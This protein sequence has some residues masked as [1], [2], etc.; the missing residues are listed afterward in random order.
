MKRGQLAYFVLVVSRFEM[1]ET[2]SIGLSGMRMNAYSHSFAAPLNPLCVTTVY[3]RYSL[4]AA[5][6]VVVAVPST[7]HYPDNYKIKV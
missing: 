5:R 4:T 7:V 3:H 6:H 2:Y 1:L